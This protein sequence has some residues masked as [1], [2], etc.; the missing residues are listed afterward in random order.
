ME[1]EY[2][3][4]AAILEKYAANTPRYTS[5]PTANLFHEQFGEQDYIDE[6]TTL[7]DRI[8]P[9]SV[10]VHIPFCERA[11]FYCG[12]NRVITRDRDRVQNYLEGLYKEIQNRAKLHGHRRVLQLHWGGGTPTYLDHSQMTELMHELA[13]N[14]ELDGSE[15]RDFSI[16]IDPRSVK[17]QSIALIRGLGFNRISLGIQ[18]FDPNVQK[19]I[20]RIQ[21]YESICE[22][23]QEIGKFDFSSVNFDLIYGLPQQS[24]KSMEETLE[25]VL[26]LK[27]DRIAC[28]NY[29]HMPDR[30]PAQRAIASSEIPS[31]EEKLQLFELISRRLA[32]AGYYHIGLDHFALVDDELFTASKAG[33]L[34]RNF[35]GYSRTLAEDL[36]GLGASAIS[37]VG[38][39]YS[40]NEKEL[41]SYLKA[42]MG[43][44]LPVFKG[45]RL[46]KDDRIR[47]KI[48]QS[49]CCKLKLDLKEIEREF[50]ISFAS[51]FAEQ[52]K[53]INRLEQDGLVR[54]NDAVLEVT[55]AGRFVL[56]NI[57]A[58]FDQYLFGQ[59][60]TGYT[61]I[62]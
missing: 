35:Q 49:I 47:K 50:D 22:L 30:F 23:M 28:Y 25:R 37:E 42:S 6:C 56:R 12:C 26:E 1:S 58:L 3:W 39:C 7:R 51:S 20:N 33:G 55:Y 2:N 14:F 13:M 43:G 16:E 45:I 10:Y 4:D 18:D 32:E 57:C 41:K 34:Y 29:A 38:N 61:K 48:I 60:G 11:C 17:Y 24:V 52:L 62:V 44:N 5:Y 19:A 46:S 53:F 15:S 31:V 54:W 36:I 27:P 59:S 9:I 40:Q 8:S 21:S